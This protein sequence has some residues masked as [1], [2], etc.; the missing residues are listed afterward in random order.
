M[1]LDISTPEITGLPVFPKDSA[2][3]RIIPIDPVADPRWDDFVSRHPQGTIFH[4]SAWSQ[5]LRERYHTSPN[6]LALENCH[7]EI[8]AALPLFVVSGALGGRRLVSL[9]C[10]EYCYPLAYQLEDTAR[11][12]SYAT[13]IVQK[14][15]L[16][17]LEIRGLKEKINPGQLALQSHTY[18]LNH[19]TELKSN[20][21]EIK[22]RFSRET[23]YHIN[24][25]E[26]SGVT[27]RPAENEEDLKAYHRL[28]CAMR[29]NIHLLP[30]PYRFF[31]S[32]YRHLI[33]PGHGFLLLAEA[34]NRIV[35]GG[36]FLTFKETVL[37]KFNAS[38][39]HFIQLRP[40]Y[41]VMWKAMEQGCERSYRYFDFGVTNPE[42]TGLIQFKK[43]W[44]SRETVL[45]YYYFPQV[46]GVNSLPETSL[47]Y[48]THTSINKYLPDFALKLAAELLY[49]RMG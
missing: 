26:R 48:R 8:T 47:I 19:V 39:S 22:A 45:P 20:P 32:I 2:E 7:Q 36:L 49:K 14:K 29:R 1:A 38:D 28:T 41:L 13:D 44:D 30:W 21:S 15:H 11:L 12:I 34:Q 18:Y 4:H 25:G 46:R 6:Y 17:Y 43:H 27:I 40:N 37:N 35:S 31:Q 10:S 24:R 9:P 42:N 3:A 5:V 33:L 16:N 23:R